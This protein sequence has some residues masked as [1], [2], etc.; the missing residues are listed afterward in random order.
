MTAIASLAALFW[1][2]TQASITGG[3]EVAFPENTFR[4]AFIGG[5]K[6]IDGYL[7]NMLGHFGWV[8]TPLPTWAYVCLGAFMLFPVLTAL[9]LGSRR[10][11]LVLVG[12][13]VFCFLTPLI[14]QANQAKYIGYVWQGRYFLPLVMGVLVLSGFTV[15][16]AFTAAP[17]GWS[18]KLLATLA[19]GLMAVQFDA[20]IV[21]HH[22]YQA[23]LNGPWLS[24]LPNEWNAPVPT[25]V[26]VIAFAVQL[27]ALVWITLRFTTERTALPTPAHLPD[28]G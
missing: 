21:N 8:D 14:I 19:V 3:G 1:I 6:N 2:R 9:A 17:A 4:T 11:R 26:L 28:P 24:D 22:R 16:R 27:A 7:A 18:T 10:D 25:P 12:L 13:S 15:R 20:F 23:G 5:L